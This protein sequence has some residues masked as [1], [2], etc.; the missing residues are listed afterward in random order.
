MTADAF[1]E[2]CYRAAVEVEAL[3]RSAEHGVGC[4][5]HTEGAGGGMVSAVKPIPRVPEAI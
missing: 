4:K 2:A 1:V 3:V 5:T